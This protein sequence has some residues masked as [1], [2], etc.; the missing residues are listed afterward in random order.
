MNLLT[1]LL[2]SGGIFAGVSSHRLQ[3]LELAAISEKESFTPQQGCPTRPVCRSIQREWLQPNGW[4]Y[5]LLCQEK[6]Y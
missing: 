4:L 1:E 6:D 3:I 5:F 2:G